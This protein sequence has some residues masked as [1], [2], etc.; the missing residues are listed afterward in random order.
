MDE[1]EEKK[2]SFSEA[3][4]YAKGDVVDFKEKLKNYSYDFDKIDE[5]GTYILKSFI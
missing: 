1:K 5:T 4:S 2:M 3:L